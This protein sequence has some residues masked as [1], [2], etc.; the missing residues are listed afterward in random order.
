MTAFLGKFLS[1]GKVSSI[2]GIDIAR[3]SFDEVKV[4]Q[5][6]HRTSATHLKSSHYIADSLPTHKSQNLV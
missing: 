4:C 1:V 3:V 2:L 5:W 6:L